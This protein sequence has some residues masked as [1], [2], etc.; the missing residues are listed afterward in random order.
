M[1][2]SCARRIGRPISA[3]HLAAPANAQ[4]KF[5]CTYKSGQGDWQSG[6]ALSAAQAD[7]D[8][9]KQR[10]GTQ[11]KDRSPH[12]FVPPQ[13]P[14]ADITNPPN[15]TDADISAFLFERWELAFGMRGRGPNWNPRRRLYK[16]QRAMQVDGVWPLENLSADARL[17]EKEKLLTFIQR[18]IV[19]GHVPEVE[20][21]AD[22]RVV[23]EALARRVHGLKRLATLTID[24]LR[25]P[26]QVLHQEQKK[27]RLR[28]ER[29]QNRQ[30]R[31]ERRREDMEREWA[32]RRRESSRDLS[33]PFY[34]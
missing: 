18:L 11:G 30:Q 2:L 15:V 22:G 26:V 20:R 3:R 7:E 5:L 31:F 29:R 12:D 34:D 21:D 32:R 23:D 13:F 25:T 24:D 14:E 1:L 33:Q 4:T 17:R 28:K 9:D 10:R 27:A 16:L 6:D 19:H 8:T